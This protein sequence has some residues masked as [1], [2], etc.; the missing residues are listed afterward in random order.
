MNQDDR[1]IAIENPHAYTR[2]VVIHALLEPL[3]PSVESDEDGSALDEETSDHCATMLP[4]VP[5]V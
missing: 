2:R 5:L 1:S 4:S 3:P